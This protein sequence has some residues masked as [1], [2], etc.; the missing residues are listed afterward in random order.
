MIYYI[1]NSFIILI[2][3]LLY[4]VIKKTDKKWS[5][6]NDYLGKVTNTVNSIRY[7]DLSSKVENLEHSNFT[8]L[9]ESLNRMIETL[10]DREQMIVE[11]QNELTRQNKFLEAIINSLSDGILITDNKNNI[12]RA[13]PQITK[14]FK[15]DG[16][17]LM[18][19][20]IFDYILISKKAHIE[21]LKN[22]EIYIKNAPS[23]SF[24]A[25]TMKLT[26]EDKKQYTIMIIK[27]ITSQVEVDKMKEDFVATLTHDLKVPIIAASNILEFLVNGT[28]GDINDKQKEALSN[29]QTS[30]NE[31]LEL[32]QILLDTYKIQANG[33]D[34]TK[35]QVNLNDLTKSVISEMNPIIVKANLNINFI[36]LS[37]I[38]ISVDEFQIKRVIKNIIQNAISHSETK[39]IDVILEA[40]PH[41]A[42]IKVKDYGKGISEENLKQVFNKYYSTAK[43]FRKIGTGLGLFLS[44]Q[45]VKSH[46]GKITAKSEEGIGTEFCIKLPV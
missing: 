26:V 39:D 27:D 22:S 31:L 21:R 41:F 10:N 45:I 44:Q 6:I 37:E 40:I 29:M 25:S 30:N 17:K 19:K 35:I 36:A 23:S 46:G 9:S 8:N 11:Y 20:N 2:F 34:L 13:T 38:K 33:I 24:Q 12:L 16:K 5:K 3:I 42:L 4:F 14:W 1:V 15:E 18:N 43:K 32:V 28:F 7:G